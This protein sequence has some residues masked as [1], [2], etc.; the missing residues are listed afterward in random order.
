M[1]AIKAAIDPPKNIA[2]NPKQIHP[3]N[4]GMPT[5]IIKIVITVLNASD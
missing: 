2:A 3:I 1:D 4:K 5:N